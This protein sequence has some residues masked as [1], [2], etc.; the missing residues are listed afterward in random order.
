MSLGYGKGHEIWEEHV[1]GTSFTCVEWANLNVEGVFFNSRDFPN[2]EC[3][4]FDSIG[5][6]AAVCFAV[7]L[8]MLIFST[9]LWTFTYVAVESSCERI[10]HKCMKLVRPSE[11]FLLLQVFDWVGI[12]HGKVK[13]Y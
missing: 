2:G 10:A 1:N 6:A 9:M 13:L 5:Y 4:R 3:M 12:Q 11:R 8:A 7:G